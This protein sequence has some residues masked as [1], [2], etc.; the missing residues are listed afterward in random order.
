MIEKEFTD[1]VLVDGYRATLTGNFT[2]CLMLEHAVYA[3]PEHSILEQVLHMYRSES[4]YDPNDEEGWWPG[5]SLKDYLE[6]VPQ[7]REV[8]YSRYWHGYLL[9]LKPLLLLT[10]FN[11]IRLLNAA[12]QLI[13]VGFVII[14]MTK[15]GAND[16]AKGFMI[17]M[18]FLFFVSTFTSLSLSVCLYI[19]LAAL[20]VQM[21]WDRCWVNNSRYGVF[22]LIVGMV[23]SYFD[24]LTYPL[25]TLAY[26]LCVYLYFHGDKVWRNV[27]NMC[28]FSLEWFFGYGGMWAGKWIL[29]DLLTGSTTI[30]DALFTIAIRTQ[31]AENETRMGGF[32][33]VIGKNLQDFGSDSVCRTDRNNPGA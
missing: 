2:D 20:L 22:F 8:S 15:K 1:E 17:S 11:S 31:S 32:G 27:Q 25:V 5:Q 4:F 7:P 23:T 10:S 16:L 19:M 30:R 6:N 29:S 28:I 14:E 33:S 9:V 18:P 12:L 3:H 26:P 24:F 21:K 13:M